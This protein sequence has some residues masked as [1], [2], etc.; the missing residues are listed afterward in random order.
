MHGIQV[1]S[2]IVIVLFGW[3][4]FLAGCTSIALDEGVPFTLV[5]QGEPL[6]GRN[7]E[8][9]TVAIRGDDS[10]RKLPYGL[11]DVAQTALKEIF[12]KPDSALYVVIFDGQKGSTGHRVVIDT[13]VRRRDTSG[14]KLVV[15][16]HVDAPGPGQGGGT[17]YTYPFVIARVADAH[18]EAA[19][20]VFEGPP[21]PTPAVQNLSWE[22]VAFGA[23]T[24]SGGKEPVVFAMRGDGAN[25]VIPAG[26]PNEARDALQKVIVKSDSALYLVIYAGAYPGMGY[27]Q[28][29]IDFVEWHR[30]P[31]NEGLI[32]R[33][34]VVTPDQTA[35]LSS[36][37]FLIARVYSNISPSDVMFEHP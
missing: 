28:V 19:A 22:G 36:H 30:G 32:V 9:V 20:V 13:V 4:V 5:A 1:R 24:D 37:P 15:R 29:V 25:H 21:H 6:G 12:S 34:R 3:L 14:V 7:S 31:Q 23:P 8:P 26:L 27:Y 10:Y 33:Y 11:P 16:Y 18:V 17:A 35:S 2:Y